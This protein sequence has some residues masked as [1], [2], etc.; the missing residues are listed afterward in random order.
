MKRRVVCLVFSLILLLQIQAYSSSFFPTTDELFGQVMPAIS[1]AIGQP[2]STVDAVDD[3]ILETYNDFIDRNYQQF[4]RYC[5]G[6]G[7]KVSDWNTE[8]GIL[9]MELSKGKGSITFQYDRQQ[10]IATVF[11]PATTR[12]EETMDTTYTETESSFP[13][14]NVAFGVGLPSMKAVFQRKPDKENHL[15]DG[16]TEL[17]FEGITVSD[18]D[19]MG[20]YWSTYNAEAATNSTEFGVLHS[21]I[22]VDSHEIVID[23]GIDTHTLVLKY[24]EMFYYEDKLFNGTTKKL[25]SILPDTETAF[26]VVLPRIATVLW[27]YADSREEKQ[28]GGYI[29][30]YSD[31]S[32]EDYNS[33]SQYLLE[34]GCSVI[35]YNTIGSILTIDLEKDGSRF[36]FSYDSGKAT[37][38]VEYSPGTRPEPEVTPSPSPT[39]VPTPSPTPSPA[40]DPT[41]YVV[42]NYSENECWKTAKNYL[43]SLRWN[44]PES[45]KIYDYKAALDNNGIYTFTVDYSAENKFGGTVRKLGFVMVDAGL[46]MVTNAWLD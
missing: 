17:V 24:P 20:R 46:N 11:Y 7:C 38:T 44:N 45:F 14:I 42:I 28:D 13:E 34:Q 37:G 18:Y 1:S 5:A 26:G 43:E 27:R 33:F 40:P 4:G 16:S 3:G 31:F 22:L 25:Q 21:V 30:T 9:T 19:D 15:E 29:E 10:S 6:I 23:Y 36:T 39:P 32:E 12:I 8:N 35:D 2:P 41:K